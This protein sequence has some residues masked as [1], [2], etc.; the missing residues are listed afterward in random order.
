M[1]L[2]MV[3][4][5]WFGTSVVGSLTIARL[6]RAPAPVAPLPVPARTHRIAISR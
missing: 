3:L 6:M 2:V 4:I 1:P 5:G